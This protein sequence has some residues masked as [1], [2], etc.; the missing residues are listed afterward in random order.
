MAASYQSPT[1]SEA[2]KTAPDGQV[3]EPSEADRK[4]I[5]V[6]EDAFARGRTL[7][8]PHEQQWFVNKAF[9]RGN[10]YVVWSEQ[11]PGGL[12]TPPAP[13][14]RIRLVINLIQPT[15]RSRAAKFLKNRP[16]PIVVPA[17]SDVDDRQNARFT[18]K[19]LDYQTRRERLEAKYGEVV[20][21]AQVYG[22]GYWWFYWDPSKPARIRTKDPLT[23]EVRVDTV[24][25]G[26]VCIEADSPW[27]L[28]VGDATTPY[29]GDQPWILRLK[30]RGLDYVRARF[31]QTGKFVPGETTQEDALR[32]EQQVSTLNS[33]GLGGGAVSEAREARNGGVEGEKTHVVVREYFERPCPDYPKGRYLVTANGVLLKAQDYLPYGFEDLANPYPVCDF[34]DLVQVGQYWGTTVCEQLIT[35]QKEYNLLRS[36]IAEHLRLMAHPKLLV[37]RQHQ[38]KVGAWTSEPGEV[39]EFHALPHLPPPTPWHPPPISADAWKMIEVLRQEFTEIAHIYPE[40][41]GQKGGSTSGYQTNLLQEATDAVHTPDVEA[42]G[43]VLEEAFYKIRRLM[44]QGYTV[45]RLLTIAGKDLEPDAFEFSGEQIDDYADIKMVTASMLPST[46]TAKAQMLL[47]FWKAGIFGPADDPEARRKVA[48]QLEMGTIEDT[49][50]DARKDE[51]QARVENDRF[52]D[53]V[54]LPTPDFYEN[55]DTH[56]RVHTDLLKSPRQWDPQMKLALIAHV[57]GHVKY[58]N[59]QSAIQLALQYGMPQIV[60]DI[61]PPEMQAQA[62][63]AAAQSAAA[64]PPP[65]PSMAPAPM[66]GA[67]APSGPVGPQAGP[68]D[69][70]A[71]A[72]PLPPGPPPLGGPEAGGFV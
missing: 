30:V 23:Q 62:G 33:Q 19:A 11:A 45:E 25:A 24:Q 67:A 65:A 52:L 20:R 36:K 40:S 21:L 48:M 8:R 43:R 55:H 5:K 71:P 49:F 66:G 1:T 31:P 17:T 27:S 3:Y 22:H 44:K 42:H 69:F 64:P 4:L 18:G 9:E 2:P 13:R 54:A 32:Y 39:I 70:S 16:L 37:A 63:M 58:Q 61:M 53:G 57:I 56:Y 51:Q 14:H 59:P 38:I 72:S 29:I 12:I 28:L 60:M 15:L 68:A 7:R 6:V 10:Q 35:P 47:D 26:D 34:P 46:P 41:E 50:N